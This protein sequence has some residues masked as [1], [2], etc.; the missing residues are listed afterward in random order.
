MNRR[1]F[2]KRSLL[3]GVAGSMMPLSTGNV[4]G[5]NATNKNEEAPAKETYNDNP[6]ILPSPQ[7]KAWM[8]LKF[9]MFIHWGVNTYYDKEWSNGTLDISKVDANKLDTEQWCRTAKAAG[10][11]YI[12]PVVKHH[13]G[14]CIW[15][16]KQTKCSVQYTPTK[17]DVLA[18]LANSAA[19]H[20]LKLGL[21]YSLWDE[22]ETSHKLNEPV[23]VEFMKRQ[24]EELLTGYGEIIELWFDGFWKK[25]SSGWSEKITDDAG[26][27]IDTANRLRDEDFIDAWR[28]EG[29]FRWQIDHLYQF[30]KQLQPDCL[31]MNNSTTAYPGVPLHPV[32]VRSG[33]KYTDV[34]KDRK[35]W[36]WLGKEHYFPLQI[37]TTMSTKGNELFPSGNWFWH[38]WDHSVLSK[39]EI[40]DYLNAAENMQA[41]LLL[42]CGPDPAGKLRKIDVETLTSLRE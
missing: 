20:G 42:N 5:Q 23:Y 3:A 13:D 1:N 9:G 22:H 26:E 25:Q 36:N 29:A 4:F 41:N 17:K 14:F 11:K 28:S 18:E 34:Q 21:Y 32:D 31:V 12:I 15:H 33:E 38:E 37:E 6:L 24:F 30:I 2:V 10:M 7:Q 40:L 27:K 35:V 39:K 8:D 19:K 16:T